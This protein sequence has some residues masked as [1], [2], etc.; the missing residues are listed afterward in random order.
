MRSLTSS[1]CRNY[2]IDVSSVFTGAPSRCEIIL[3]D[4]FLQQCRKRV[5]HQIYRT[6]D[7]NRVF[8]DKATLEE[9]STPSKQVVL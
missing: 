4:T 8:P 9:M 3:L 5:S 1:L 6:S 2:P 7:P